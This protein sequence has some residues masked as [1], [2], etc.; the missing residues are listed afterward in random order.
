MSTFKP[1]LAATVDDVFKLSFPL[2]ASPKL[3]GIRALVLNGKLVSR[4]LKPIP[5][6]HLQAIYGRKEYEGLDGELIMGRPNSGNVFSRTS[7]AVMSHEGYPGAN[8]Y[9][10]DWVS[11][12]DAPFTARSLIAEAKVKAGQQGMYFVKHKKVKDEDELNAFETKALEGGFEGVMLRS[13]DGRYKHGRSTAKEQILMKLKR[14]EDA[15]A[16]IMGFEEQMHNGNEATTDKLGAKVRSAKKSGMSGKNTLGALQV[17]GLNGEFKGYS[18][19]IGSGFNDEL[20]AKIWKQPD[21]FKG[22]VVKYKYFSL[23]SKDAPR[24]PVFLGFRNPEDF[25]PV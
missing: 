25:D 17:V 23:G 7:S 14:F 22:Q 11:D 20:R 24:F 16:R 10:F 21:L 18:F 1:L 19:N 9:V 8:F 5:N 12:P 13:A 3:D 4:S 2:L 15:E 6:K